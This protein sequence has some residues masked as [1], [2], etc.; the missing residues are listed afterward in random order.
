MFQL[1]V[2]DEDS[3]LQSWNNR[4]M[5]DSTGSRRRA[6]P[7]NPEEN[8]RFFEGK[9]IYYMYKNTI[10][11]T[12]GDIVLNGDQAEEMLARALEDSSVGRRRVKRKFIGSGVRRWDTKKPIIY[13]FDGSHSKMK[14]IEVFYSKNHQPR[15]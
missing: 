13:S 5:H 15:I 4:R 3:Q 7:I 6:K 9:P 10:Q 14:T 2:T 1:N 8:G 11:L 12:L